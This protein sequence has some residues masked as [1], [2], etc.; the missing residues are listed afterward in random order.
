M[1][2]SG[3]GPRGS[4]KRHIVL[5]FVA[6]FFVLVS[7]FA[8]YI[9][10]SESGYRF[11]DKRDATVGLAQ[12]LAVSSLPWV[13]SNDVAGLQEVVQ[14]FMNYPELRYAMVVSPA[15]RVMAH[16][17]AAKVGLFLRDT[18]AAGLLKLPLGNRVIVD[19]ASLVDVAVPISIEG[20]WLAGRVPG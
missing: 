19:N 14:S 7:S 17:D 5:T 6:G 9:V 16:S 15:G 20:R 11:R 18:E 8:I 2:Y 12:S 1:S 10:H 3:I 13:L 4:F